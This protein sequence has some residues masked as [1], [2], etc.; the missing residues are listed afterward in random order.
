[1]HFKFA[2]CK[3]SA[4]ESDCFLNFSQSLNS[5]CRSG[6][7]VLK[8]GQQLD[9]D[10]LSEGFIVQDPTPGSFSIRDEPGVSKRSLQPACIDRP[11]GDSRSICTSTSVIPACGNRCRRKAD[12]GQAR[13]GRRIPAF[14][15]SGQEFATM[16][17]RRPFGF[18]G[19]AAVH[20]PQTTSRRCPAAS[21]PRT[22]TGRKS[23]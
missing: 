22:P 1:M 17:L 12:P 7:L 19:T 23:A 3:S 16:I 15:R 8:I 13:R 20:Q 5:N 2:A 18:G 21:S 10:L 11:A 9:L 6:P 14:V 4:S